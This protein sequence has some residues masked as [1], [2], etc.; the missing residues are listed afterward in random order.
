MSEDLSKESIA[1]PMSL[2]DFAYDLPSELIAQE[3][4]DKRHESRL[5]V[6]N[7]QTGALSHRIFKDI[8]TYLRPGDLLVLNDTKV[9]PARISAKRATGGAVEI[10]LL[11]PEAQQP[12]LW[13]A[14]AYPLKKLRQGDSIYVDCANGEQFTLTVAGFT[15][16]P[17]FQR[18]LLI[19]FGGQQE[20]YSL[21]RNIGSAP[22]PPYILR[23][24]QESEDTQEQAN[25]RLAD[26]ERYQ[27]VFAKSPG[28]VAAPTAGLHFS[29][30]LL[31]TLA[32]SGVEI[33]YLTL[34]VGPG[35]FKPITT[36]VE[37][38]QIE[39]EEYFIPEATAIAV[40]KAL[41][42]GRRIIA[43]GTTSCRALETAGRSGR[44]DLAGEGNSS[45]Y[46]SPGYKFKI[47]KALITNFHLSRSS[48]LVLVSSFAGHDRIMS[49]YDEAIRERYRFYSYGDAMFI[50]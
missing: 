46:I 2:D 4:C 22:L 39:S 3:P 21:L 26:M 43:V 42:E 30:E 19:D 49:A 13:Q 6:L 9:I 32:T 17:D 47:V 16:G 37:G 48:L 33:A 5:L 29:S 8:Q 41:D 31:G 27:T 34:H 12:G 20:V 35:T 15:E 18:R 25:K 38:H 44:I 23:Q 40:N 1:E 36:S 7:R 45:L 50:C 24:R 28:A 11:K 14:M 10:L